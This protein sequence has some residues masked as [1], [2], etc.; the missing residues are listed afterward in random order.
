M[1]DKLHPC[2]VIPITFRPYAETGEFACFGVLLHCPETGYI[3]YRLSEGDRRT[4]DR[5]NNFFKEIGRDIFRMTLKSAKRDLE[6]VIN[7]QDNLFEHEHFQELLANLIRPRENLIRY[8]EAMAVMAADP[9]NELKIQYSRLVKRGFIDRAGHY[10][11][12]VRERVR[13]YL[14]DHRIPYRQ[15][16]VL[17]PDHYTF[18]M[19]I[20]FDAKT[21]PN[22]KAVKALNL[23]GTS[24]TETFDSGDKWC[25]RFK[26]LL[27]AGFQRNDILV[28]VSLATDNPD[29]QTAAM[30]VY[31][32]LFDLVPLVDS[33]NP[34]QE[35]EALV[36][37]TEDA[38]AAG[39]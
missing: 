5:I 3:N 29:I 39:Y 13:K 30:A 25:N 38:I 18:T 16:E 35:H 8:G 6:Q 2:L 12:A 11:A 24:V 36:T 22:G 7:A 21:A 19:P 34:E 33:A 10:E 31:K 4:T 9:A 17:S 28:P 26:R 27:E 1:T 23:A 20:V 37:F 15:H 14:K 32:Q